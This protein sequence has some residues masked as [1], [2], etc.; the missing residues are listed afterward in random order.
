MKDYN[1]LQIMP[2][3]GWWA[4]FEVNYQF[5]V[6]PLIGWALIVQDDGEN[7]VVGMVE[8]DRYVSLLYNYPAFAGFLYS[9]DDED[10][11][12]LAQAKFGPKGGK[13]PEETW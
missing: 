3:N 7:D 8:N 1:I 6:Q 11:D 12:K 13:L 9:I 5:N 2:A 10:L 4:V